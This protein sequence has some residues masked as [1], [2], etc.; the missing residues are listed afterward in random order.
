VSYDLEVPDNVLLPHTEGDF[1]GPCPSYP[2]IMPK[3]SRKTSENPDF[4]PVFRVFFAKSQKYGPFSRFGRKSPRW[5]NL[6]SYPLVAR[7]EAHQVPA[8]G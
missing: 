1:P 6:D 5:L 3:T 4:R 8:G 7:L 2:T